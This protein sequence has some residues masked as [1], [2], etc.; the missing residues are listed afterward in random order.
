MKVTITTT[1]SDL[2][3]HPQADLYQYVVN[4]LKEDKYVMLEYHWNSRRTEI[5]VKRKE[6]TA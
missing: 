1:V 4:G 2:E 3:A 6:Q 5:V